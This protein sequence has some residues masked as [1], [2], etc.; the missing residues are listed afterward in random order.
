MDES[1]DDA[2]ASLIFLELTRIFGANPESSRAAMLLPLVT[3]ADGL[4]FL[5]TV[6]PGTSFEQLLPLAQAWRTAHPSPIGALYS[7]DLD[8][9]G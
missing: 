8:S 1:S 4:A 2:I 6:P 7:A 9:A 5:R 3:P